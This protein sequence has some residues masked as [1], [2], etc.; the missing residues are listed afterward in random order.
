MKTDTIVAIATAVNQSGISIIRLS[1]EQA[2]MVADQVFH[3]KSGIRL[4]DAKSHTMHYGMIM[5]QDKPI[6]EVMVSVMKAPRTYTRED[7]VEIN[8]HGGIRV[9][10]KVLDL[11]IK[12]GARPAEP[13]EFTKRAFL[14]GRI[15]LSQA[16]AVMD[17]ISAQKDY[18]LESSVRQ[19]KGNIKEGLDEIRNMILQDV[20]FIEAA[21]DD[22]EHIQVEDKV[23]EISE[24]VD[25]AIEKLQHLLKN[26]ETGRLIK[27]G[28]QTVILGKP[29]AGKS[30]FLNR[31]AGEELAIVT[32]IAGT[33]RD[34]LEQSILVGGVQLNIIDTAGIR[35]TEDTIERI[36][37][38]RAREKAKQADLILYMIDSSVELDQSDAE[39]LDMIRDK[40]TIMLL[41][42]TDLPAVVTRDQMEKYHQGPV[43][44]ISAKQGVGMEQLEQ[45][46]SEMFFEGELRLN[47]ELYITNVRQKTALTE[48]L[49]S[50]RKVRESM[51]MGMP[52]DFLTID[53]MA[54]YERLG[55]I[56]GDTTS[57]DLAERIFRDFCMGK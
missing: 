6:D 36:G 30:S 42:K 25:K 40:K 43:Y 56:T 3:A 12:S 33:T 44:E 50:I 28:I 27:E 5:D 49:D 54:A 41:N 17:I 53:M 16:E 21:L 11:V 24:H 23:D 37:V 29:N 9:T 13:G 4:S 34:T 7:V 32:D 26:A 22:P 57:E 55:E 46:I 18:A 1:G 31:L 10:R 38:E 48:A 35:E 8:C 19:L 39:I 15:D 51:D 14:N 2:L 47:E 52:E 45:C 20:A